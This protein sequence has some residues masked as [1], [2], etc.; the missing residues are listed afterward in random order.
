MCFYLQKKIKLK[1]QDLDLLK[2]IF[3]QI[4]IISDKLLSEFFFI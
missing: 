1:Q 3:I 2:L 4:N